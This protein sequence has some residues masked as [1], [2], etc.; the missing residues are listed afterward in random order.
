MIVAL[1]GF[2]WQAALVMAVAAGGIIAGYV[3][4]N[5]TVAFQAQGRY[6]F[7]LLLPAAMLFTGGLHAL[8]PGRWLKT[9]GLGLLLIWLSLLN[10]VGLTVVSL[11]R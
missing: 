9:L 7:P 11:V 5:A 10:M 2:A 1:G 4:F 3:Q 8:L 6:M